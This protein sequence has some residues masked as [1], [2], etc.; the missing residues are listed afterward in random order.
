[1]ANTVP[2]YNPSPTELDAVL[3]RVVRQANRPLSFREM[4][5]LVVLQGYDVS[6]FAFS[7][8]ADRLK[9]RGQLLHDDSFPHSYTAVKEASPL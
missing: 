8:S 3:L 4:E 1:M 2:I 7:R 6:T 5:A 9:E